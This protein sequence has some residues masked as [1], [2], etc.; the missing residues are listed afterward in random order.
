[1]RC[2]AL[3]F[4]TVEMNHFYES[5]QVKGCSRLDNTF[6]GAPTFQACSQMFQH[7]SHRTESTYPSTCRPHLSQRTRERSPSCCTFCK[8]RSALR[9][10]RIET[11]DLFA[12]YTPRTPK[13]FL[14]VSQGSSE[15]LQNTLQ[16]NLQTCSKTSHFTIFE[17]RKSFQIHICII[18]KQISNLQHSRPARSRERRGAKHSL[19]LQIDKRSWYIMKS[20]FQTFEAQVLWFAKYKTTRTSSSCC[21]CLQTVENIIRRESSAH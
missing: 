13:I 18:L 12:P 2:E 17:K 6:L 3:S 11:K 9:R 20:E 16:T 21:N 19:L 10:W 5:R 4:P 7:F 15:D 1:M 14:E 8:M